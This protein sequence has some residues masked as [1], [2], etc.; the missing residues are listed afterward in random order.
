MYHSRY[1]LL[2]WNW[3][4]V[5]RRTCCS[6]PL[7]VGMGLEGFVETGVE[8][9]LAG[10]GLVPVR[11]AACELAPG[12]MLIGWSLRS[13]RMVVTP[14]ASSRESDSMISFAALSLSFC[15]R[16][17]TSWSRGILESLSQ[18]TS[19]RTAIPGSEGRCSSKRV[20]I[21]SSV[22]ALFP[23]TSLSFKAAVLLASLSPSASPS[24]IWHLLFVSKGKRCGRHLS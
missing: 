24:K 12:T 9:P 20:L 23:A 3:P 17:R 15:G 5:D 7:V 21:D 22:E 16:L 10:L 18:M 13:L 14:S 8:A 11:L 4:I 1:R 2:E 6:E 19:L